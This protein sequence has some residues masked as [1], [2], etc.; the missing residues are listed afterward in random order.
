MSGCRLEGRLE[1]RPA[2]WL[3]LGRAALAVGSQVGTKQAGGPSTVSVPWLG[4]MQ[5]DTCPCAPDLTLL[6]RPQREAFTH[7]PGS[8]APRP[9]HGPGTQSQSTPVLTGPLS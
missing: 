4:S 6:P 8:P 5:E 2:L 7:P 3:G 1:G 9:E